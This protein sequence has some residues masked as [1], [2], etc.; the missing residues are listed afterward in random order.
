MHPCTSYCPPTRSPRESLGTNEYRVPHWVQK[1]SARP[2]CPSCTPDGLVAVGSCRR[3]V[4]PP[5]PADRSGSRRRDRP[6]ECAVSRQLR[7]RGGRER[8]RISMNRCGPFRGNA[9]RS[10]RWLPSRSPDPSA[11]R[12]PVPCRRRRSSRRRRFRC[13][14][15]RC[16][17]S[18][19]LPLLGKQLLVVG[20]GSGHGTQVARPPRQ[21]SGRD[22]AG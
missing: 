18:R 15:V 12:L 19:L 6:W 9:G 10:T 13:I 2:G 16:R 21:Q 1:P 11:Q 22:P 3:T 7:R 17:S 4:A 8:C 5:A 20:D 14:P